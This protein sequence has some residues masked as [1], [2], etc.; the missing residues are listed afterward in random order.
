MRTV[1]YLE[2]VRRVKSPPGR[3]TS[4]H[5]ILPQPSPKG[6]VNLF[7]LMPSSGK[8]VGGQHLTWLLSG[9]DCARALPP[10]LESLHHCLTILGSGEPVASW[11]EV[12]ADGTM[13][14][15]KTLRV[16]WGFKPLHAPFP[17]AGRLVGVLRA[18]VGVTVLPMFHT[19]EH[20]P[21]GGAVSHPALS[22]S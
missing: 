1:S 16:P 3:Q 18:I 7:A 2:S 20:F 4:S 10:N 9:D 22:L 12:W 17:L 8:R 19:G 6:V 13:R 5:A 14:G 11:S 21:F 15:E